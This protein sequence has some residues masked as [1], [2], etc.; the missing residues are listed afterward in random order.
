MPAVAGTVNHGV[1]VGPCWIVV[2]GDLERA[3]ERPDDDQHV[4][5]VAAREWHELSHAMT[6]LQAHRRRVLPR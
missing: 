6:V 3:L 2:E 5:G 4:E 1:V